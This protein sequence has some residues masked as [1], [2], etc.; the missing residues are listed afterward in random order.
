MLIDDRRNR[1][2]EGRAIGP[3]AH[4]ARCFTGEDLR[5]ILTHFDLHI[6]ASLSPHF[7]QYLRGCVLVCVVVVQQAIGDGITAVIRLPQ[8]AP[9]LVQV[10]GG[11]GP[12]RMEHFT[13]IFP[14]QAL[15]HHGAACPKA[16]HN[17]LTINGMGHG[18]ANPR[19]AQL[20]VVLVKHREAMIENGSTLHFKG[21]IALNAADLIG[22]HITG[23]LIL[24]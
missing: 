16:V 12:I 10:E 20:R 19:I 5:P 8:Q 18:A 2:I 14:L 7:N 23:E 3:I 21:T 13:I 6:Q 11:Y 24:A 1:I 22:R 4:C 17:R 15:R 9:C